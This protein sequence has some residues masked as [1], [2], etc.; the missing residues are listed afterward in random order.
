MA[1]FRFVAAINRA[2]VRSVRL[3]P[4][5][6]NSRSCSTRRSFVWRSS[7]IS[8]TSSRKT[9]PALASSNRPMRCVIAPVNAP[10]SWPNSSLSRSPV[11]IA[12]Q[13][14]FTKAFERRGLR[15]WIARAISSFPVPVSPQISTVESVDATVSASF[16]TRRSTALLPTISSKLLSVRISSRQIHALLGEL[17]LQAPN[18]AVGQGVLHRDRDLIGDLD[19]E[20]DLV[21]RVYLVLAATESERAE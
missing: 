9:V 15:L 7:G 1:R 14:S 19:Q 13:F 2:S 18:L 6:S 5:L 21:L 11:G 17:V 4:N 3:L 8:P 10:F 20:I 12:A 16:N